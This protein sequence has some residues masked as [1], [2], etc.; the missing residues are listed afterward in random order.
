MYSS[1][2]LLLLAPGLCSLLSLDSGVTRSGHPRCGFH[3]SPFKLPSGDWLDS[4]F[5]CFPF[6]SIFL[7][8]H[9]ARNGRGASIFRHVWVCTKQSSLS[10]EACSTLKQFS[11]WLSVF[12]STAQ[13]HSARNYGE[14]SRGI[15]V[16][17]FLTS[18][19]HA[20]RQE[21]LR[22][23]AHSE[24][25]GRFPASRAGHCCLLCRS[26]PSHGG[27]F[28]GGFLSAVNR[29][30]GVCLLALFSFLLLDSSTK[31]SMLYQYSTRLLP[32][33]ISS[34]GCHVTT[35]EDGRPVIQFTHVE[36]ITVSTHQPTG[37]EEASDVMVLSDHPACH[38]I[39]CNAM[40]PSNKVQPS[41]HMHKIA[42]GSSAAQHLHL[43]N[44]ASASAQVRGRSMQPAELR[45]LED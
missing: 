41:Q 9:N 17:N 7:Q 15:M 44:P 5:L 30:R 26:H 8:Y 31:V 43:S 2:V 3:V 34:H 20:E 40:P 25:G 11:A 37:S 1:K 10:S 13:P 27:D 29:G 12:P 33:L 45:D 6:R 14:D 16:F 38:S 36:Y 35:R 19:G 21:E 4:A 24:D 39:P 32:K 22:S 23:S 18:L 42:R 28:F